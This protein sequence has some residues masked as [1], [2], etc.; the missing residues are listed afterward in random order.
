M[1]IAIRRWIERVYTRE[2]KRERK[3]KKVAELSWDELE[4]DIYIAIELGFT[5]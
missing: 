4:R 2:E 1:S 3:V 5:A